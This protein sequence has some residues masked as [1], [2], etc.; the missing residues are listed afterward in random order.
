MLT[1]KAQLK[2]WCILNK[3]ETP[4]KLTKLKQKN[5]HRILRTQFVLQKCTRHFHELYQK[6]YRGIEIR[7]LSASLVCDTK[8]TN[9][10]T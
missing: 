6:T 10:S 1:V 9:L 5:F 7:F 3:S 2:K 4:M 8:Y